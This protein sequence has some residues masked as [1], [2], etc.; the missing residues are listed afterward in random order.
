MVAEDGSQ[1]G[2]MSNT[3]ALALAQERGLDL[4]E[5]S[6]TARPPVCKIMDYGKFKYEEA[7][8]ARR[9][10]RNQHVMAVKEIKLRPK[11]DD[12][13]Y[14]FKINHAREFLTKRDKVKFTLMFRGREM[15]HKDIARKILESAIKDLADV[16]LVEIPAREEGRTMTMYMIP[17]KEV[18]Q[19]P[20]PA[21]A[22][23][24]DKP[25]EDGN[26]QA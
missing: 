17:K 21:A 18:G 9:A 20:R 14:T 11:I 5:I 12:H 2:I 13:D 25:K 19:P 3:E 23:K 16:G 7:K 8:Q 4:V 22:P 10:R 15:V 24:P 26:A 6:P 1:L